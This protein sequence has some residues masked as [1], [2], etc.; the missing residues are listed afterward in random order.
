MR[1]LTGKMDCKQVN[2]WETL[3]CRQV[4]MEPKWMMG[5]VAARW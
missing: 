5:W 3:D 2:G 4:D 1:G